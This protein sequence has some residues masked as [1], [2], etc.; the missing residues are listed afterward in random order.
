LS[1]LRVRQ[2]KAKLFDLF[3]K[4]LDLSD[5]GIADKDRETKILTRCLAAYAVYI[6]TG[7]TEEDAAKAVWDGPDDNGVDAVYHDASELRIVIVQSKWIH[8]G[9]GEPPAAD[10]GTFANSVRDVIEENAAN[11][12]QR[13]QAKLGEVSRAI[14]VP[15]ATLV[16]VLIT[17]G[18]SELARHGTANLDRILSELNEPSD[19]EPIATHLILGLEEV[20]GS[21]ASITASAGISI[22]A[23]ITE[24]SYVSQPY[25]AYFGIIDGLQLKEWWDIYGKRLV[26]KN[27]RYALGTTDI[28]DG[29]RATAKSSPEDFW[30]FNNGITLIADEVIRAPK[31]AA[32]RA[33]G[34]FE[35]KGTSIV[36]GA[37]TVST[38]G[39]VESDESLDRV[40]VPIR[41]VILADA[42]ANF[43]G[44]VTRTNNLQNRVE[45]RDFVAQDTEQTRLQQEMSMEGVEYQFLRSE[46]FTSSPHACELLE[47]TTALACASADPTLAVQVK[48]GIGRFF[49]DLKK[50]PYKS[51][52]NP[53]TSGARAFNSTLIHRTIDTWIE[54]KRESIGKRSGYPW[55]VLIHGNRILAAG[56]FKLLGRPAIDRP[57]E[58][59]RMTMPQLSISVRCEAIYSAI[60]DALETQYPGKF[61]AVLFKSLSMSKDVFDRAVAAAQ[62]STAPN[63]IVDPVAD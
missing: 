43:G 33:S 39:R 54:G 37:Q 20:Y 18:A 8:A 21:L 1:S 7:C 19:Q 26:A 13:L 56:V 29:I 27:I 47:V 58:D 14:M 51:V 24:W 41:I 6:Q 57:I 31:A 2:I 42:P 45:G 35:F 16:I 32:S 3:E 36:N 59:F 34:I 9:S 55:G 49:I 60:V 22:T 17:T 12:G 53:Q 46:D 11:F 40:K 15:G 28:N 50:A 63:A 62:V 38:L 23:K 48:T 5:I 61:L 25:G 4:H 30:Y 44:E 10:I 52:F